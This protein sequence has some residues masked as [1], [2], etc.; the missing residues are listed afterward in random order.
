MN[1]HEWKVGDKVTVTLHNE[2]TKIS[3]IK[4]VG[5]LKITLKDGSE[6]RNKPYP[7]R[8]GSDKWSR[9]TFCLTKP[10]DAAELNHRIE[11]HR[12]KYFG[13]W[14]KLSRDDIATVAGIIRRWQ[15]GEKDGK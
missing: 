14:D 15:K 10:S 5:T 7:S 11:L 9:S 1:N 2:I 4:K 12:V 3:T 6:W 13:D 8:W